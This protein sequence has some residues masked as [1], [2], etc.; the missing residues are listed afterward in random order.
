MVFAI[1]AAFFLLLMGLGA[2]DTIG[3]ES[4]EQKMCSNQKF[5]LRQLDIIANETSHLAA[6]SAH[7]ADEVSDYVIK[8]QVMRDEIAVRRM[9]L[10]RDYC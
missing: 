10:D 9:E 7:T 6:A 1:C 8:F 3:K 4:L 2:W 5:T